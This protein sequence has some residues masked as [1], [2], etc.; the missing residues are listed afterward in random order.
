LFDAIHVLVGNKGN[1]FVLFA[2]R[3]DRGLQ[4]ASLEGNNPVATT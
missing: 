2:E 4:G 1:L 3:D